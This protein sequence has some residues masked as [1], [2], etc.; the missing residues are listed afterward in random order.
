MIAGLIEGACSRS[1]SF[2]AHPFEAAKLHFFETPWLE[3]S[4]RGSAGGPA[5]TPLAPT[6]STSCHVLT[7]RSLLRDEL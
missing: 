7:A 6:L 2:E 4:F 5:P 3:L 1:V